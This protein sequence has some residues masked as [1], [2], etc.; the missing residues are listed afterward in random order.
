MPYLA[1]LIN[2]WRI[3]RFVL[4]LCHTYEREMTILSD[5]KLII[6]RL[7]V[8][9]NFPMISMHVHAIDT[10]KPS[11]NAICQ[12]NLTIKIHLFIPRFLHIACNAKTQYD[13]RVFECT[14]LN[15]ISF[16]ISRK[17]DKNLPYAQT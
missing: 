12:R 3:T 14:A 10:Q 15:K 1:F 17:R 11:E 16:C 8:G 5:K 9:V 4:H 7:L 6:Y 2:F 13:Y